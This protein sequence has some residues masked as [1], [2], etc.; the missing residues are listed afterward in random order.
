MHYEAYCTNTLL[1]TNFESENACQFHRFWTVS[2]S[3]LRHI[4]GA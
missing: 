1:R 2:E 4:L 3:L